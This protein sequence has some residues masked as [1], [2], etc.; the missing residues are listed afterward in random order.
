MPYVDPGR[1]FVNYWYS[2][3]EGSQAPAF[4]KTLRDENQ[5]RLERQGGAC[6]MYTHFGH[7]FVHDGRLNPEFRRL[8]ERLAR[9][10]GWF[11]PVSTLLDFLLA[12]KGPVTLEDPMRSSLEIRWLREKIFRGTS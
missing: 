4:L 1:P 7:G 5:D 11:V 3:S 10:N 2:S 6:I 9:K 8:M 12:A